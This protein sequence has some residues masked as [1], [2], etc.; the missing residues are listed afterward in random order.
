MGEQFDH[1][2]ARELFGS[3]LLVLTWIKG[4]PLPGGLVD[5]IL[6]ALKLERESIHERLH[7]ST[8]NTAKANRPSRK[9]RPVLQEVEKQ[10]EEE[11][12]AESEDLSSLPTTVDSDGPDSPEQA[13]ERCWQLS[14][15]ARLE[16]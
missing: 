11:S 2:C 7:R 1:A 6:K 13:L 9:S 12:G 4:E 16:L 3:N 8:V 5:E 14:A 10:L 15:E